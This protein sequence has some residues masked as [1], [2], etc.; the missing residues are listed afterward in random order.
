MQPLPSSKVI[1]DIK[2]VAVNDQKYQS[3]VEKVIENSL[4]EPC[5]TIRNGLLMF[6]ERLVI[7]NNTTLRRMFHRETH[8]TSI[9]GHSRCKTTLTQLCKSLF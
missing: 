4:A 2:G 9:G 5:Y 7:P 8:D 3:I 6:D 1:N